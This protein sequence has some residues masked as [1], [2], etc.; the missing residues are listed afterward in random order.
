MLR[1]SKCYLSNMTP[2]ERIRAGECEKDG[3][4]YFIIK[5]N[6][7]ALISQL[8]GVYNIPIVLK[9]KE[10]EKFSYVAEIRSMSEELGTQ[11]C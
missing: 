3:G 9:Q 4:E 6:E 11:F 8:R 7:R 2:E 5:G 1:S 10:S